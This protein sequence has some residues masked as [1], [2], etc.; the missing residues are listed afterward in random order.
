M[1]HGSGEL[2]LLGDRDPGIREITEMTLEQFG[3][4]VESGQDGPEIVALCARHQNE[5]SLALVDI[6]MP[7]LDGPSL[8]RTLERLNPN[9]NLLVM[10]GSAE[11]EKIE[12]MIE[13]SRVHFL[14][15]LFNADELLIAVRE[16]IDA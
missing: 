11:K 4:R 5:I 9:L 7:L 1:P 15:K 16:R 8:V 10:C 3:Y 13:S 12:R 2:I 14:I 6:M